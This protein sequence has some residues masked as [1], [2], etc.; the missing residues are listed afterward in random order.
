M[1]FIKIID[2]KIIHY[3]MVDS[4]TII[5]HLKSNVLIHDLDIFNIG[6]KGPFNK[7]QFE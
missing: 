5:K 2:F 7:S 4:L 6:K 1:R 3:I